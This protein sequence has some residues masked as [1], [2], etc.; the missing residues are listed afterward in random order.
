MGEVI[1]YVGGHF[2][3]RVPSGEL[4]GGF[5]P[6]RDVQVVGCGALSGGQKRRLA[7]AL[8]FVGRLL[9]LL[10]EPTTGL[11]VDA[12]T[13]WV[14]RPS[15]ASTR[16][17][18]PSSSPATTSKRIE[19]LAQRVIVVGE[20]RMLA[21]DT[22]ARV[23]ARVGVGRVQL[24]S[25]GARAHRAAGE[26]RAPRTDDREIFTVTDADEFVRELVG[27]GLAFHDL[28]VRGATPKR[29]SSR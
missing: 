22:V 4:T 11:D 10:D 26:R 25:H 20:G 5:R 15:G 28:T 6:R 3:D 7:V 14:Q 1:D 8:A 13:L 24:S 21:D 17:G 19:A 16:P 23:V 2:A 18:P 29:P 12:R 27:S 9:V